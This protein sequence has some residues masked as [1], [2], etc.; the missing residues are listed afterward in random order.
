MTF[1]RI[2]ISIL[3]SLIIGVLFCISFVVLGIAEL[4]VAFFVETGIILVLSAIVRIMWFYDGQRQALQSEN[5]IKAKTGLNTALQ[6]VTDTEDFD[7]F[8]N[9]L[10]EQ[11][12]K[13]YIYSKVGT[14]TENNFEPNIFE[15]LIMKIYKYSKVEMLARR[16]AK[17]ER[18]SNKK[19]F[20]VRSTAI[21]AGN[22]GEYISVKNK[23][24]GHNFKFFVTTVF[25]STIS[26]VLFAL[27]D[28][29]ASVFSW[30]TLWRFLMWTVNILLA[31]TLGWYKGRVMTADEYIAYYVQAN[32]VVQRYI[33]R[34]KKRPAK[35]EIPVVKSIEAPAVKTV[36]SITANPVQISIFDK[37]EPLPKEV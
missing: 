35:V 21:L 36:E 32:D 34:C 33:Q 17:A 7:D 27:I 15:K 16:R 20:I 19:K 25:T 26:S 30:D 23:A 31:L 14:L 28:P 9:D 22:E 2:L 11:N 10:S 18:S 3:T 5:V 37:L 8:C 13:A 12:R 1:Y 6:N 24:K 4:S 29:Q